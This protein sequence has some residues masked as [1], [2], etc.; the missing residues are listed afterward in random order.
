MLDLLLFYSSLG[1]N[2]FEP[3][4]WSSVCLDHSDC[5]LFESFLLL[6]LLTAISSSHFIIRSTSLPLPYLPLYSMACGPL[7]DNITTSHVQ[8]IPVV[9]TIRYHYSF[10]DFLNDDFTDEFNPHPSIAHLY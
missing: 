5:D 9:T 4:Y 7:I 10:Q 1:C 2:L 3:V 8:S 6:L